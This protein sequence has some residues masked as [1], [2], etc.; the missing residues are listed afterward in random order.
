MFELEIPR[1]Q[2]KFVELFMP[3]HN[4]N[5]DRSCNSQMMKAANP[6]VDR[7]SPDWEN[8]SLMTAEWKLKVL[9]DY[10]KSLSCYKAREPSCLTLEEDDIDRLTDVLNRLLSE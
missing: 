8:K 6:G 10:P 2:W 1:S 9:K 7:P 5:C 3:R 4:L